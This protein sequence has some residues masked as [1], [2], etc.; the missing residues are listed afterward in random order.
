[1]ELINYAFED[2]EYDMIYGGCA[3]SNVESYG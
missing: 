1:M 2:M 3:R